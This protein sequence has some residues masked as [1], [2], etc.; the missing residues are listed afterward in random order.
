MEKTEK[1]DKTDVRFM[2]RVDALGRVVIPKALRDALDVQPGQPAE[3][4]VR[5][6][7]LVVQGWTPGCIFCGE[8]RDLTTH[9]GKPVCAHCEE[10]LRHRAGAPASAGRQRLR[11][12]RGA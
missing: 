12:A 8:T 10:N 5:D 9:R 3:M 1:T 4:Y 6:G 7:C 11:E 2:R